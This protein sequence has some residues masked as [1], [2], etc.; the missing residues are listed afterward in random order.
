M[1]VAAHV[2]GIYDVIVERDT[3]EV[4]SIAAV[5]RQ[6]ESVRSSGIQGILFRLAFQMTSGGVD[7]VQRD[8]VRTGQIH[9]RKLGRE[10]R[11]RLQEETLD[12][13]VTRRY[14]Q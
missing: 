13:D 7:F 14:F 12:G 1:A 4:A 2:D 6:G 3:A 11:V 10:F 5:G 9:G 8:V